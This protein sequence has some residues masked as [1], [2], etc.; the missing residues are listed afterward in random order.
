MKF[1][2][3]NW[4]SLRVERNFDGKPYHLSFICMVN[5]TS[6]LFQIRKEKSWEIHYIAHASESCEQCGFVRLYSVCEMFTT[7]LKG[8]EDTLFK[9]IRTQKRN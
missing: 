4:N 2:E 7:C 6:C 3:I 9:W 5:N 1:S 8:K